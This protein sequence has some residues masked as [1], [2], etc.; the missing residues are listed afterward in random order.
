[1]KLKMTLLMAHRTTWVVERTHRCRAIRHVAVRSHHIS[2]VF[3]AM[4]ITYY[5]GNHDHELLWTIKLYL[6]TV[7]GNASVFILSILYIYTPIL[8]PIYMFFYYYGV[9]P[10]LYF[11][12]SYQHFYDLLCTGCF[13]ETLK[14]SGKC[15]LGQDE[16]TFPI[17]ID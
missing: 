6:Q 1:M 14:I 15:P 16:K 3:K 9:L 11:K 5:I 4:F 12:I 2:V 13:V 10:T 8:Q 17:K 7:N